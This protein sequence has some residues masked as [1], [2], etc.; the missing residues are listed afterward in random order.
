MAELHYKFEMPPEVLHRTVMILDKVLMKHH[1]F[2]KENLQLL[3][4]TAFHIAM[5]YDT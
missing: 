2:P 4:V 5:K 3:G 1:N